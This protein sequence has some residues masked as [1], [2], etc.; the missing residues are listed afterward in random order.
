[1]PKKRKLNSKNPKYMDKAIEVKQ[2][3]VFIR[4]VKGIKIYAV[5]NE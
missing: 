4:E 5:Y 2:N 3:K 1:M